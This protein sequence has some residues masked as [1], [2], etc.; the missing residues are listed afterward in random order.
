VNFKKSAQRVIARYD[1]TGDLLLSRDELATCPA[2]A[3]AVEEIDTNGDGLLDNQELIARLSSLRDSGSGMTR[4]SIQVILNNRPLPGAEVR[5]VP[6]A[7][8]G[9][10]FKEASGITNAVGKVSPSIAPEDRHPSYRDVAGVVAPGFYQVE[11]THPNLDIPAKYNTATT[12]GVEIKPILS[13][14]TL[15]LVLER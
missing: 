12:L 15:Q 6:E 11:I 1:A 14:I 8:L 10:N 7:F 9:R 4:T 2:L 3:E 13:Q 5:L